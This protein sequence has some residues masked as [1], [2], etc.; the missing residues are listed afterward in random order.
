MTKYLYPVEVLPSANGG[1]FPLRQGVFTLILAC[2]LA[3]PFPSALISL[4]G[5]H[6]HTLFACPAGERFAD[7][8]RERHRGFVVPCFERIDCAPDEQWVIAKPA[9]TAFGHERSALNENVG[10]VRTEDRHAV[11]R[12]RAYEQA[13]DIGWRHPRDRDSAI[14][15]N[16]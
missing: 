12:F 4:R 6:I 15:G 16:R 14:S 10:S 9:V 7:R 8:D 2:F 5:E 11:R 13:K 3:L 1:E